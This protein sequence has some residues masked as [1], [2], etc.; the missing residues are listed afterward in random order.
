M[1]NAYDKLP[2][3]VSGKT[4]VHPCLE[5]MGLSVTPK[6][7]GAAAYSRFY[8]AF[9]S[10]YGASMTHYRLNDSATWKKVAP[11]D[12]RKLPG[13]FSDAGSLAAPLLGIEFHGDPVGDAPR[14]PFFQMMFVHTY[15]EYPRGMFRIALPVDTIEDDPTNFLA[16][17]DDAMAE[18]PIHW[19]TAGHA[20]YWQGTDTTIDK[21][22]TQWVGRHIK[23]HPGLSTGDLFRW[24]LFVEQGLASIGWLTFLGDTLT[25][26]IGGRKG[27]LGAAKAAGIEVREYAAGVALRAAKLPELGDVNRKR[28]LPGHRAVGGIVA[29]LFA[30][31]EKLRNLSVRG[32]DDKDEALAWLRR[33]LP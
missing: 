19:G 21:Y 23:K 9:A 13:W 4:V 24:G 2:L 14:P 3:V 25:E 10:R 7:L 30:P 18:F 1:T 33:F 17:V 15:P 11:K 22:A 27:V 32:F 29:P 12:L 8:D 16:L 31:V 26:A 5:I 28:D 20:F 6:K